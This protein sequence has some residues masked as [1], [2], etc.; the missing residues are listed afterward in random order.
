MIRVLCALAPVV[1]AATA[2]GA[3]PASAAE[4]SVPAEVREYVADGLVARLADVYGPDGEGHGIDFDETT[5][6]GTIVR[7]HVWTPEQLAGEETDRPIEPV[8]E[9]I[10]P[11]S[12]GEE[13]VGVATVWINPATVEPELATFDADPDLAAVLSDVPDDAAL[14]H[15]VASR[16]WLALVEDGT[17]TA[18]E[19]GSTGLSTP[20]PLDDVALIPPSAPRAAASDPN[21]G[22]GLAIGVVVLLLIVIAAALVIPGREGRTERTVRRRSPRAASDPVRPAVPA[23]TAEPID[24]EDPVDATRATSIRD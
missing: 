18:L 15:D 21:T 14:V 4:G 12:I 20:V 22:L 10:V 9:W 2:L 23:D 7:V 11:V 24:A 5:R 1:L 19:P 6:T 13:P 17:L 8:N 16:A 3:V